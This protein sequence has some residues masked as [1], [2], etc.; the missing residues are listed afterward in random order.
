MRLE[1][2]RQR[3]AIAG[4]LS[5]CFWSIGSAATELPVVSFQEQPGKLLITVG[6]RP[7]ATYVYGDEEITRPYFAHVRA[8]GGVQVTRNHPPQEGRDAL[9]HATMHPGIWLS[10]ADING[11]DYWR[12]RART[13]H[14]GFLA[15]PE[16]GRG[17]GT[18]TVRNR[19]LSA[20]D[21]RTVCVETC[22]FT[23]LVRPAGYLL[24]YD[25]TF[26]SETGD[27]F[28]GDQEEFGLGVRVATPI[29][30]VK[31]GRITDSQGRANEKEV[32]GKASEWC[33]YSGKIDGQRVGVTLMPHP[34]NF[35][36]CWYHARDYGFFA[37]NPFGQN[38]MTGGEKSKVVVQK[39]QQLRLGYGVLIYSSPAEEKVDLK[40]AYEDYVTNATSIAKK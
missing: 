27:F 7:F 36:P 4:V 5:F 29:A 24:I 1:F 10:F 34:G 3:R 30:V 40:A 31:G 8:P 21:D 26:T 17:R 32:W 9:D 18:F 23:I 37:A 39:G 35:R 19:Y 6:E 33:D 25:S 38:A 20:K 28:F 13:V 16:G 14:E 12:L 22:R 11:N 15:S 2:L